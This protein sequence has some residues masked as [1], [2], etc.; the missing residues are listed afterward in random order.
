MDMDESETGTQ[1][2]ITKGHNQVIH[3][4]QDSAS[5]LEALFNTVMNPNYKT[6]SLPMKARNFP[7]SFFEQPDKPRHSAHYHHGH[8]QS[9]GGISS[10]PMQVNHSRSSSSDS[11]ASHTSVTGITTNTNNN[12]GASV[13][14][15]GIPS[16][17]SMNGNLNN[18][19]PLSPAQ[20]QVRQ[21]FQRSHSLQMPQV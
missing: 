16:G 21:Q 6:K 1:T 17:N 10:A 14:S 9:M 15:P 7:K 13:G 3:V 12:N 8:S 4:R 20:R 11:N 18:K 2:T 5:E 19:F